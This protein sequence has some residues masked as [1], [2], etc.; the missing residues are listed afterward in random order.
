MENQNSKHKLSI[1]IL[2]TVLIAL[3]G[4]CFASSTLTTPSLIV[5]PTSMEA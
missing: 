5:P 3:V 1:R 4:F 2:L